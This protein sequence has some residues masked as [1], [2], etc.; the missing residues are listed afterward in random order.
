MVCVAVV[1][2]RG[3]AIEVLQNADAASKAKVASV[4]VGERWENVHGGSDLGKGGQR[5]R[6]G[7]AALQTR[8]KE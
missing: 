2:V 5:E 7:C 8:E 6:L 3:L 4:K 1:A